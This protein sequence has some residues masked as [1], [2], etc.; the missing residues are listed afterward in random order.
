MQV[1]GEQQ[2]PDDQGE[3]KVFF[4]RDFRLLRWYYQVVFALVDREK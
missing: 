3:D 1:I 4:G 2:Q